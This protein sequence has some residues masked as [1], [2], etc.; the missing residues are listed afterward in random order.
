M[1]N[2]LWNATAGIPWIALVVVI[3]LL[4]SSTAVLAQGP[5]VTDTEKVLPE[6]PA[7]IQPEAG[8]TQTWNFHMQSTM[9]LQGYP[10]FSARYSG[11]NSL[12]TGTQVRETVSLDLFYGFRLWT[13]A[14]M[15]VDF[16]T[17]QGFGLAGTLGIDDFP[18]G[19]AYKIGTHPPR[20]DLARCFIRQT[21][22]LGGGKEDLLGDQ[23]TLAGEQDISRI[24]F[25]VLL[26][27][28]L[29]H[30]ELRAVD[31]VNVCR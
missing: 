9:T 23:L 17:W 31:T 16:L 4:A 11:P 3:C 19:E 27:S 24:T 20:G 2:I 5:D 1:K 22:G 30:Q 7:E 12:P 25:Q 6:A 28:C 29:P 14:E 18:D 8:Q 10:S 13:G 15:H 21:I 26:V